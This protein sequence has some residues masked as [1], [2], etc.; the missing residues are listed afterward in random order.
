ML[1][2]EDDGVKHINIYSKAKTSLGKQL[3]NMFHYNFRYDNID[4]IS[5]EQAWHF[6]K[7]TETPELAN[8][9]L[10]LTNSFDCLKFARANKTPESTK[11]VL[12]VGFKLII[13][14]VIHTRIGA[15][16]DLKNLLRNS[17]L[18]FEHYY[19][20]GDKIHDQRDKY[21][22]LINIFESYRTELHFEYL[23]GLLSKYGNLCYNMRT[24]PAD[25]I[26][27]GRPKAGQVAVY[28]NP[29]PIDPIYKDMKGT[30]KNHLFD[31]AVAKSVIEFRNYLI[32]EIMKSPDVWYQRLKAIK[33]KPLKCFCTNGT[34]HRDKGAAYCHTLVLA[35]FADNLDSIYAYLGIKNVHK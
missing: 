5:V 19:A 1:K 6:Y 9:I 23:D 29:F 8:Q 35:Q 22:W 4:F 26:Y 32:T 30:S 2:V 24:A 18:P 21:D 25:A 14:D 27:A 33:Q 17:W 11:A 20:Y 7:F 34:D 15:D 10:Q 31:K 16:Q 12:S 3:T 13:N 28:G